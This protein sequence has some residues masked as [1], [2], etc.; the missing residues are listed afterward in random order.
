MTITFRSRLQVATMWALTAMVWLSVA[1]IAFAQ[2][3]PPGTDEAI[4][5]ASRVERLGIVA[6]LFLVISLCLGGIVALFR[7]VVTNLTDLLQRTIVAIDSIKELG[8]KL[9]HAARTLEI[10]IAK[11]DKKG[12]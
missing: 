4:T 1:S 12:S 11:C 10:V 2:I 6:I 5:Q 3:V 8:V 7:F 9:E